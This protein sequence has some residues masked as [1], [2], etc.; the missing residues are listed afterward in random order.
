MQLC[1]HYN[2]QQIVW[3]WF[4]VSPCYKLQHKTNYYWLHDI[5]I[6]L[7]NCFTDMWVYHIYGHFVQNTTTTFSTHLDQDHFLRMP[8]GFKMSQDVY[9]MD[10]D[11]IIEFCPRAIG[12]HDDRALYGKLLRNMAK[13]HWTWW[14]SQMRMVFGTLRVMLLSLILNSLPSGKMASSS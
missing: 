13:I 5:A 1:I 6:M 14:R 7:N 9:Q 2:D 10:V 3:Y 11:H 12:I 8:V 4:G